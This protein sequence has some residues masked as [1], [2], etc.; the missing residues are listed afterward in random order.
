M[1]LIKICEDISVITGDNSKFFD[2]NTAQKLTPSDLQ[3]LKEQG[4]SGSDIIRNLINNSETWSSK[5]QFAQQKWLARKQ[6]R[7]VLH[8][9]FISCTIMYLQ[10]HEADSSC[11]QHP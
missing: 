8:F 11:A 9:C 3:M 4:A 1:S 7:L 10:I 5:T 6:K 2:T